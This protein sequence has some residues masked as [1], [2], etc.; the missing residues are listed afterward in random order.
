MTVLSGCTSTVPG[1]AVS[2]EIDGANPAPSVELSAITGTWVGSYTCNQGTTGLTLTVQPS[3][4]TEFAFYPLPTNPKAMSGR[5]EMRATTDSGRLEFQQV[6]W[7]ER[8]GAY[9]MVDL[10]PT[11]H[12]DTVLSGNVRAD[13]CSTFSVSRNR[14]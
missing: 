11:R 4:R 12:D 14:G 7:I 8:P 3:G 1:T 2:A 10:Q 9:L 5:F 13:G 6:R